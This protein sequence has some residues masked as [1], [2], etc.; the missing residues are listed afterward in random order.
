MPYKLVVYVKPHESAEELNESVKDPNVDLV[1]RGLPSFPVRL[2]YN[3]E[4]Q[5]NVKP[6]EVQ[7]VVVFEMV[8]EKLDAAQRVFLDHLA[9]S[10]IPRHLHLLA[11][12]HPCFSPYTA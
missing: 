11:A 8:G 10:L 12:T 6:V 9:S 5:K 1:Y 2:G 7:S 4:Y 3:T